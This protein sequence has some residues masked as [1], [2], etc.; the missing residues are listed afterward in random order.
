MSH[1]VAIDI[2]IVPL[3]PHVRG[4]FSSIE[5]IIQRI[6]LV[7]SIATIDGAD[8]C[9]NES[10][11][12]MCICFYMC[13]LLGDANNFTV[14][15]SLLWDCNVFASIIGLLLFNHII[16]AYIYIHTYN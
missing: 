3:W 13:T 9:P 5:E 7:N 14:D 2:I 8:W 16:E 6:H 10:N 15:V 11:V 1:I 4:I 12:S